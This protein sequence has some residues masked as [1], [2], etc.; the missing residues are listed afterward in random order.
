MPLVR[1][2]WR[3]LW[4]HRRRTLLLVLVVGYPAATIVFFWGFTDGFTE[5]V[6]SSHGR[7]VSAPV[8]VSTPLY[9][10]D[11]DPEHALPDLGFVE[12]LRR[13]PG[14]QAVT[15]RLAF[16]ALV[17]SAYT[18]AGVEVRGVDAR[19]EPHVSRVAQHIQDGRMLER[20]GEV[21][22]GAGLARRLDVRLGER[23]VIDAA[24]LA[25]PQAAGL[26]L[27][28]VVQTGVAV[29]DDGLVW[30]HLDDARR[31]TGVATATEVALQVPRGRED[32]LA[33]SL[34]QVLP[35]GVRAYGLRQRLGGLWEDLQ[36]QRVENMVLGL[37]LSMF[38][39]VAVVSTV[40]IRV[41][42]RTREFG[43]LLALGMNQRQLARMVMAET[44]LVSALGWGAGLVAGY[45]TTVA[46]SRVNL[47]GGLL[48]QAYGELFAQL[49][50][51]AEVYTVARPAHALYASMTVATS[52][53][54]A[55]FA[56]VARVL[57]LEPV[58]AL[59][60]E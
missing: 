25:G 50:L 26:V 60:S 30:V 17:T 3:N 51:P 2:A 49:G 32:A 47:L 31:L 39:A 1:L 16:P 7:L 22:L 45:A 58:R 23:L 4:R 8:V 5:S 24:S 41:M 36:A 12:E 35:E 11:P 34:Q 27:V 43:M 37:F 38:A 15:M 57:R 19:A 20:P 53:L 48:S 14:V 18:S 13:H 21:V 59:R 40:L 52:V 42:Q 33:A 29:V 56:P 10:E 55:L 28:G 6:L 44:V 46:L 9:Q 54:L